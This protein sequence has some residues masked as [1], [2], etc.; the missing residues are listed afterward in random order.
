ME[1]INSIRKLAQAAKRRL[2]GA[3]NQ[4]TA[5]KQKVNTYVVYQNLYKHDYQ[6]LL[7][8]DNNDELYNKV[9]SILNEDY[10]CPNILKLLVDNKEYNEL[11]EEQKCRY[12][13]NL[14][15]KYIMLRQRYDNEVLLKKHA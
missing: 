4:K 10:D 12:M 6:I 1:E 14:A 15:D 13:L 7:Y 5:M 9:C 3:N 2:N 11:N 8:K